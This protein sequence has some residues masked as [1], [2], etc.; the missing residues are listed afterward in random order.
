LKPEFCAY[1]VAHRF[2]SIESHRSDTN[3]KD[4]FESLFPDQIEHAEMLINTST[5]EDIVNKR[6]TLVDKHDRIDARYRFEQWQH[7]TC[8]RE[9]MQVG[10]C[11][12]KVHEPKVP[13][14]RRFCSASFLQS[15]IDQS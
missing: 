9:G 11:R 7:V 8:Q 2:T 12:S 4:V 3:L 1:I 15:R 14:V 6:Q 5:L 10:C 13:K